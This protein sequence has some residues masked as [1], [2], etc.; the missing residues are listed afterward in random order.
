M[1][2]LEESIADMEKRSARSGRKVR[3][4]LNPFVAIGKNSQEAFDETIAQIFKY[5]PDP[6]TRKIERRMIP[7]TRAGCMG[8]PEDVRKQLKRFNDIGLELI[9]MKLLP[10]VENVR[11]LGEEIIQPLRR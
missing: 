2:S 5:D 8:T 11:R 7:A 1:K 9:L 3:Y 6:D 10:N 4:A